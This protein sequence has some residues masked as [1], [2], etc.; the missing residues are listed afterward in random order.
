MTVYIDDY[1]RRAK[2]GRLDATWSHLMADTT[3]ELLA[4]ARRLGMNPRW[5]Q[6]AGTSLEHFDV[7]EPKRQQALRLG[8]VPIRYGHEGAGLT[9]A[10]REGRVFDLEAHRAALQAAEEAR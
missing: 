3:E 8:A 7:T 2:V 10:K 1:Q 4:F 6:K 5:I 9:R